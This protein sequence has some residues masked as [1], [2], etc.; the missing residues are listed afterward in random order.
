MRADGVN[1]LYMTIR[2][3]W[4]HATDPGYADAWGFSASETGIVICAQPEPEIR[5][6]GAPLERI[7]V[8]IERIANIMGA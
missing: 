8:A 3:D 4:L 7:A 5:T 1:T 6:A 2:Q